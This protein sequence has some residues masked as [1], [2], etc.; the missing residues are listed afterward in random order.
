MKK[1]F[2]FTMYIIVLLVLFSSCQD[3]AKNHVIQLVREWEG[4][5]ILF[6]LNSVF[7]IQGKDT[8]EH[9]G[10]NCDY[11]IVTYID[12]IGCTSCKLQ[13]QN[14]KDFISKIDSL[15]HDKVSFFFYFH[16]KDKSELRFIFQ[17]DS[18]EYPICLDENDSFNKLN[19][20]PSDMTFQTFLLNRNNKVL[21]IGNPIHNPK[22]KELYIKIIRGESIEIENE[23]K[24]IKTEVA[25]DKV[26]ISLGDFDW[27]KEQK[28]IFTLKNIGDKL[29]IIQDVSTSCG[30]TSV[31]YPKAPIQPHGEISLEV[32]YKADHPEHFSKTITVYCNAESS[33]VKLSISGNAE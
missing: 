28:A 2:V 12:S 6:P 1:G 18:F 29:L 31:N 15:N 17:R 19:H 4:K 3:K 27:Q 30:C 13:L 8:I 32:V 5:E 25:T 23:S 22:I 7:T 14:W 33:P 10:D 21:A 16:P 9:S 20:F 11:K 24:D 26:A